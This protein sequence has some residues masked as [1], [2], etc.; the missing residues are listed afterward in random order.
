ME[1]DLGDKQDYEAGNAKLVGQDGQVGRKQVEDRVARKGDPKRPQASEP[2]AEPWEDNDLSK[3]LEEALGGQEG[4]RCLRR[5]AKAALKVK[6]QVL[7]VAGGNF[8]GHED[9]EQLFQGDCVKGKDAVAD[10]IEA[11]LLG[12][13]LSKGWRSRKLFV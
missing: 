13:C 2:P 8:L 6:R 5:P 3:H 10:D 11:D 12:E 9:G 4:S 1:G 7:G